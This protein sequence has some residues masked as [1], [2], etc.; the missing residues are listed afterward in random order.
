MSSVQ[1]LN[2]NDVQGHQAGVPHYNLSLNFMLQRC[3]NKIC[4][5]RLNL[6]HAH[7]WADRRTR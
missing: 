5:S 1:G 6:F 3:L 4:S 7:K 2:E